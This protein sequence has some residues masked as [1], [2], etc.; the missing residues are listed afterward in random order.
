[1][2][3]CAPYATPAGVVQLTSYSLSSCAPRRLSP[4]V[5]VRLLTAM[6]L[7]SSAA[8]MTQDLLTTLPLGSCHSTVTFSPGAPDNTTEA[9]AALVCTLEKR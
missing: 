2:Y 4:I 9:P 8:A 1:M 3:L 6:A 7:S 5:T